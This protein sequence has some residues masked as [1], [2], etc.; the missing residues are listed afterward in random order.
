MPIKHW[1]AW[2]L[3]LSVLTA[4]DSRA[5]TASAAATI[6]QPLSITSQ[7]ALNFGFITPGASG[8]SVTIMP[9]NTRSTSGSV[10]VNPGDSARAIFA[11]QGAPQQQYS[12]QTPSFLIFSNAESNLRVSNFKTYSAGAGA[13]TAIGKLGNTGMDTIYLGGTLTVPSNATPGVYS[14]L[15]P[16]TISY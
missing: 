7:T 10:S 4:S 14:G 1:E 9:D 13:I 6:V 8:G 3:L 15:V 2:I 11:V 5:L 16:L 12:I